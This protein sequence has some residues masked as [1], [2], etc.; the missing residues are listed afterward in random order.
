MVLELHAHRG[1]LVLERVRSGRADV[2]VCV[3]DGEDDLAHTPLVLEPMVLL[4]ASAAAGEGGEPPADAAPLWT[5][6]P[7]SLTGEWLERRL[8]RLGARMRPTHRI[9]SFGAAVQL[10]R[11]GFG[12]A[13]VPVGI[14]RAMGVPPGECQPV[15][16][17]ARPIAALH[18]P[19]SGGRPELV[20]SLSAL[21]AA[22]PAAAL[23]AAGPTRR[24]GS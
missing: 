14:A 15:P 24:S 18:S 5:I 7:R 17:L 6:E 10:A 3:S 2:G 8:G 12:R 22:C 4:G 19:A 23:G 1:P 11:A 13:R 21:A 16:G 9:E 20:R